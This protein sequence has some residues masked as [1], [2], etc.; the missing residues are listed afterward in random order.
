MKMW[1][2]WCV[3]AA[4]ICIAVNMSACGNRSKDEAGMGDA[5]TDGASYPEESKEKEEKSKK[6]P[7]DERA[8]N[9]GTVEGDIENTVDDAGRTVED[10]TDGVGD[11]AEELTED[12]SPDANKNG[13]KEP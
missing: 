9:R 8:E 1:K 7:D 11:A 13:V 2:K 6:E 10:I 3:L 5:E 12:R 4:C